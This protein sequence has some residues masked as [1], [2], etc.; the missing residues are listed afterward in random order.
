[1]F[2]SQLIKEIRHKTEGREKSITILA[3]GYPETHIES[4]IPSED[5][6]NLKMKIDSGADIILT[7]VVFSADIFVGFLIKCREIGI[8]SEVFIIPGLYIPYSWN[9]LKTIL[10]ITKVS[11][12]KEIYDKFYDLKD[13]DENFKKFSLNF[14]VKMILDIQLRSPEIIRGFHF[15]TFN[16]FE[17][18]QNI[19]EIVN[20]SEE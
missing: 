12:K 9:E 1:M 11:M 15:F 6:A 8:S 13:D 20:F 17:M 4:K 7:Q 18:V 19:I 10:R 3:G 16:N 2:A 5:L 14:T